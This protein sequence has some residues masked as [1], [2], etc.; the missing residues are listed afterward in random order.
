MPREFEPATI[1][2][3]MDFEQPLADDRVLLFAD[4]DSG[5]TGD[6]RNDAYFARYDAHGAREFARYADLPADASVIH[7]FR[8]GE[9]R[10]LLTLDEISAPAGFEPVGIR[11]LI[12][13]YPSNVDLTILAGYHLHRWYKDNRFC[14]RCGV[15]LAPATN[16]R[17]LAC[18]ACGNVIYPR[19][20]PAIIVA[21]TDDDRIL[22]T[23]YAHGPYRKRALVAG[24]VEVGETA[25]HAVMREVREECG[26]DVKNIRYFGSQPWGISGSLMLG[27][28]AEL[29]GSPETS[30]C[31]GEL[32]WAGWVDRGDIAESDDYAL[33]RQMVEAFRNELFAP[34][35]G[36]DGCPAFGTV[37]AR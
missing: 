35:R 4:G 32:S 20:S 29:D 7:A 22:M 25:E 15:P 8:V 1:S 17:A 27:Y 30:L 5:I 3:Q 12:A 31:D 9:Q 21:V 34:A 13:T 19:I 23:R 18:A 16:E 26:L 14:G 6:A 10:F 28:F 24:F 36:I 2:V 11:S 33:G 37:E